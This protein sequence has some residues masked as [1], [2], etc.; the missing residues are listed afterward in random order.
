MVAHD[1]RGVRIAATAVTPERVL[2]VGDALLDV[3]VAPSR[4]IRPGGD[5]PAAVTLAPGGQGGNVAVRLAR[6]GV[7][8]DLACALGADPAGAILR[9]ALT[10]D[11]VNL[12]DLETPGTG[13]VV[14]LAGAGG[15]RTMLSQRPPLATRAATIGRRSA[16]WVVLSGYVLAEPDADAL[17]DPVAGSLTGTARRVVLGCALGNGEHAS[18]S[19]RVAGLHADV[20]VLNRDEAAALDPMPPATVLIVTDADG[21]EARFGGQLLRVSGSA[22]R[23][24]AVDTT[25]AGDAFA[26][27]LVA[28]LRHR[29]WPPAAPD[30]KAA[31]VAGTRLAAQVTRV[32]GA[33]TRVPIEMDGTLR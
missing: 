26:A 2:V 14:V 24:G 8:V 22:N 33:Q 18:W 7:P 10:A 12:V 13:T 25:G 21:A 6:R 11:G 32:V 30:L 29:T 19:A 4:E 31:M 5:V 20:L 28:E 16:D 23:D 15:E 3:R 9:D 27:A 1:A 17:A